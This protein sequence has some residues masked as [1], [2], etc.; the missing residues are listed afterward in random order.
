[1]TIQPNRAMRRAAARAKPLDNKRVYI[2]RY[3]D[4]FTIF[5]DIERILEMLEHGAIEFEGDKPIFMSATGEI[6]F[7]VPALD[8]WIGYWERVAK[9]FNLDDRS[10]SA[11]ITVK[12]RLKSGVLLQ[13]SHVSAAQICVAHQRDLYERLDRDVLA[14]LARTERI[15]LYLE[16]K[17]V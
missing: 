12:K 10:Y 17:N 5:S 11:L 9:H 6:C 7:V 14:S 2:P 1:M 13:E 8:G 15:A 4:K 16:M 3:L